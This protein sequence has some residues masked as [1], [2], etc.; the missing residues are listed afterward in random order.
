MQCVHVQVQARMQGLRE[1]LFEQ[2]TAAL[3]PSEE[4]SKVVKTGAWKAVWSK[5]SAF[6]SRRSADSQAQTDLQQV[7]SPLL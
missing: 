3:D 2:I 6:F 4:A 1:R 7:C 5:A